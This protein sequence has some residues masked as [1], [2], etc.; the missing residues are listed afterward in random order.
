MPQAECSEDIAAKLRPR[1]VV[2]DQSQAILSV[3]YIP[4]KSKVDYDNS[5]V[6]GYQLGHK[7]K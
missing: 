2:G 3:Q 1:L 6:T 4:E 5:T 7:L